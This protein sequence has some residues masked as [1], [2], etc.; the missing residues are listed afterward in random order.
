MELEGDFAENSDRA[1]DGTRWRF[2]YQLLDE[3]TSIVANGN[4]HEC[5]W[6]I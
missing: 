4:K 3:K 1:A 5:Q 6:G 2:P